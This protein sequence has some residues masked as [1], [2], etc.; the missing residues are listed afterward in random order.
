MNIEFRNH[1][2]VSHDYPYKQV[3]KENI[4]NLKDATYRGL[5]GDGRVVFIWD[6]IWGLYFGRVIS[7]FLPSFLRNYEEP[8]IV[9][10]TK[11]INSTPDD[12]IHLEVQT[13]ETDFD[14][15]QERYALIYALHNYLTPEEYIEDILK[16]AKEKHHLHYIS[17]Y[18]SEKIYN[19]KHFLS[20]ETE[21]E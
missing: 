2:D 11:D 20:I 10:I 8:G 14:I 4:F 3:I 1:K 7:F 21:V 18:F 15:H 16:L 13:N 6:E 9:C 12:Y 19:Y 17:N 5:L